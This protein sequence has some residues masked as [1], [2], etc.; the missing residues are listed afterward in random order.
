MWLL[1]MTGSVLSA[2]TSASMVSVLL[3]RVWMIAWMIEAM[4]IETNQ[5]SSGACLRD[6][7]DDDGDD[8][9]DDDDRWIDR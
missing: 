6:D 3:L 1:V 7:D 8:D 4:M 2:N 5:S 9:D